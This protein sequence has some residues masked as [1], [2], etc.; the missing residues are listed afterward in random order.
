MDAELDAEPQLDRR[1]VDEAD[2]GRDRPTRSHRASREAVAPDQASR[3]TWIDG[4]WPT[5]AIDGQLRTTGGG[6]AG[7]DA[8]SRAHS[9][10]HETL[11]ETAGKSGG[12]GGS[13]GGDVGSG[14]SGSGSS[15]SSVSSGSSGSSGSSTVVSSGSSTVGMRPSKRSHGQLEAR[16]IDSSLEA[17]LRSDSTAISSER[18]ESYWMGS[19]FNDE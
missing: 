13:H 3:E 14:S 7:W 19:M 12:G 2:I 8:A 15:G 11:V 1:T 6:T 9:S 16:G 10:L 5:T 17:A 4:R 18:F